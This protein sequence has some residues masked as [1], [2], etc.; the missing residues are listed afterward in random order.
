MNL[1]MTGAFPLREDEQTLLANQGW[2]ILEHLDEAAPFTGDPASIDAIVCSRFF[3]HHDLAAFSQLKMIQLTSAGTD[4]ISIPEVEGRGIHLFNAKDVYS[5]PIAEWT[6]LKILEIAKSSPVFYEQQKQ[7]LWQKQRDLIELNGLKAMILGFGDIGTAIAQRLRPFGVSVIGVGRRPVHTEFCDQFVLVNEADRYLPDCDLVIVALPLNPQ[8]LN[9]FSKER[10]ALCKPGSILI[11]ISRG[12]VIDEQGLTELV[13]AD[14]FRGV[15]LD[16]FS[17][18][19][20]PVDSP[21]WNDSRILVSPHNSFVSPRNRARLFH[22]I[23]ENLER[24][25]SA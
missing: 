23:C 7:H 8:T 17:T 9:Y 14:H 16:V 3:D 18:E 10:L 2:T 5:I 24:F 11:N 19:P 22:L 13:A 25:I 1:L 20:L 6:I 15:A 12:K 21:L 4:Q